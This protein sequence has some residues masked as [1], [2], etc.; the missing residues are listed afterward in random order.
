LVASVVLIEISIL[1]LV[2]LK[3]VYGMAA[4][5]TLDLAEKVALSIFSFS[6]RLALVA[7]V[8]F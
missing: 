2:V 3:S 4:T 5:L 1:F 6:S 7:L 8:M